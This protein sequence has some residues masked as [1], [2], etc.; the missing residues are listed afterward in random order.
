MKIMLKKISVTK[1]HIS[2]GKPES[3]ARCPVALALKEQAFN[4][5]Y[6]T[7]DVGGESIWAKAGSAYSVRKLPRS[8]VR[9]INR[10]DQ[11]KKVKPFNF[12]L[13]VKNEN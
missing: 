2:K 5:D 12:M 7:V 1:K 13:D 4:N 9:F 6:D 10:F 11:K 8:V 3:C